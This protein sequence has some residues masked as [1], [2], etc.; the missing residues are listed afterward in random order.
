MTAVAASARWEVTASRLVTVGSVTV[1]RALPQHPRR[2][3]GAWCFADHFGP[4]EVTEEHGVDVGPHP[5]VGL[6]TVTWLT[7]GEIR[8]RDSLGT[9]QVVRAGELNLMTAGRGVAHSEEAT[10]AYRG[11]LQ[12]VQL[13]VAQPDGTRH[14]APGFEHLASLPTVGLGAGQATVMVGSF[15]GAT[16]PARAD[17]DHFGAELTLSGA[18]GPLALDPGHEH[19]LLVI[20]GAVDTRAD[21]EDGPQALGPGALAY[22]APGARRLIVTAAGPSRLLLLGGTPWP[23]PPLMW[24]NFVARTHEEIAAARQD[25]ERG[26][27]RFGPF[28]SPLPRIAA[29][30]LALRLQAPQPR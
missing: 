9:V 13:W 19:A 8:H 29:P 2:T 22:L 27:T 11:R 21:G 12:G 7:E 6:Q 30:P 17:T 23:T 4:T 24:W 20:D 5:H 28:A 14:D 10:G 1:R 18:A 3:V 25:W 26:A 15:A 16:S